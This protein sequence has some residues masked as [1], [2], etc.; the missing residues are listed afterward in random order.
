MSVFLLQKSG[1]ALEQAAQKGGGV[2]IPEGVQEMF[3]CCTE[4]HGLN[5][6]YQ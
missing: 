2:I 5:G 4:A 1:Q 6:K 3:R